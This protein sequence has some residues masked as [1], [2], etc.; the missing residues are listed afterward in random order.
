LVLQAL[1]DHLELQGPLASELP[2]LL[3]HLGLRELL[4]LQALPELQARL[5]L[6]LQRLFRLQMGEQQQLTAMMRQTILGSLLKFG[7]WYQ[8]LT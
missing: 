2:A 5:D 7:Q 4:E 8:A 6:Q 3:G 1:L